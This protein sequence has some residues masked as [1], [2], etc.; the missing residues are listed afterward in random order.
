MK[1]SLR[2]EIKARLA[3]FS[4]EELREKSQKVI[5]KLEAHLEFRSARTVLL[6]HSMPAEVFTHELLEK[7]AEEK[8][9]LLPRIDGENLRL[10]RYRRGAQ[11]EKNAA[12]PIFEPS[13]EEFLEVEKVELAIIPAMAFS[14]DG[15]RLGHGKGFYDRLLPRL[16]AKLIGLCFDF[17]VLPE[18]PTEKHDINVSEVIFD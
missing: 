16:N 12:F 9:L 7:Y 3:S 4:A 13:G 6:Y 10:F 8:C 17:Q 2:R 14:R 1:A 11:L 18:I 5:E 15:A